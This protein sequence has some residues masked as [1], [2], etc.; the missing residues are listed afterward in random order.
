M[1]WLFRSLVVLALAWVV[2]IL[3]P[4]VAFYKLAKAVQAKDVAAITE[5]VNFSAVRISLSRQIASAYAKATGGG[6]QESSPVGQVAVSAGTAAIDPLIA[7]YMTPQAIIDLLTTGAPDA[8]PK[9][10]PDAAPPSSLGGGLQPF[11]LS[12]DRFKELF[13]ASESRGFRGFAVAL[14]P[15]QPPEER[16]RLIFRLTGPSR[17]FTWRLV[18]LELPAR[19]RDRLV[20]Q[21]VK[22]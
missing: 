10:V 14:P 7:P 1:R 18:G 3:S 17:G 4:Y 20:Q 8:A 15:G 6:K 19:L 21:F 16:F 22:T 5:R 11:E 2:F 9:G 12:L 13:F